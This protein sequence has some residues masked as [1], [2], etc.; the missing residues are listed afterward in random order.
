MSVIG[1]MIR[2]ERWREASR[3]SSRSS[4]QRVVLGDFGVCRRSLLNNF[5]GFCPSRSLLPPVASEGVLPP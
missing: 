5:D 3:R 2:Q 4:I 1:S